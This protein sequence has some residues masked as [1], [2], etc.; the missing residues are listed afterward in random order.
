MNFAA[1]GE[2]ARGRGNERAWFV[3][4]LTVFLCVCIMGRFPSLLPGSEHANS[5]SK[6][7]RHRLYSQRTHERIP[8]VAF[9]KKKF[10]ETPVVSLAL[11]GLRVVALLD[12]HLVTILTLKGNGGLK[13]AH[14]SRPLCCMTCLKLLCYLHYFSRPLYNHVF[15]YHK[16]KI[17]FPYKLN[18]FFRSMPSY[19]VSA[20]SISESWLSTDLRQKKQNRQVWKLGFQLHLTNY[21]ATVLPIFSY[22]KIGLL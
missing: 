20:N 1:G 16:K 7:R 8:S 22:K 5:Q 14:T 11:L 18:M 3:Q 2:G 17:G 6:Y 9:I 13:M 19:S 10:L 15:F 4:K 21:S 12:L